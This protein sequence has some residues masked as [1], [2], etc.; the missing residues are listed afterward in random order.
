MKKSLIALASLSAC[1]A[2]TAHAEDAITVVNFGG[3][4]ANAQKA[5]Y[6]EP[7]A[8]EGIKVTACLLYT[9]PSPRD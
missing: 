6:Y 3:A 5:A 9:S 8:K 7:V 4:N 2:F 1:L